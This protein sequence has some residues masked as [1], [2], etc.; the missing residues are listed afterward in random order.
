MRVAGEREL[1]DN[2]P[3]MQRSLRLRDPY[4]DPLNFLQI[5]LL[6]RLARCADAGERQELEQAL[7]LSVN[8]VAAGLRNTG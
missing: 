6:R 2:Q 4:V 7:R 8:G 1:L 5:E 3:E